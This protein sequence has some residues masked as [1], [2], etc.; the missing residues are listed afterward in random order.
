[1]LESKKVTVSIAG[2]GLALALALSGC[3]GKVVVN[4]KPADPATSEAALATSEAAPATSD[5][6]ESSSAPESSAAETSAA[7]GGDGDPSSLGTAPGTKLKLGQK[8]TTMTNSGK[9]GSDK[10]KEASYDMTVT[11]IVAGSNQDLSSFDNADKYKGLTPYY[12][13]TDLT[14]T[15]LSAP[16][17]G[18]SD[19]RVNGLLDNGKNANRLIVIGSFEK[20]KS[21]RFESEGSGDSFTYKVGSTKETCTVFL[22]P[23]GKQVTTIELTNSSY[24]FTKYSD[25]PYTQDPITWTK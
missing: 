12:V 16:S 11:K 19:P 17:A 8:A 21:G 14:L 6:P 25:N 18:I 5:A 3:A 20:C 13:F 23:E 24:S 4:E 15:K 1:M 2:L 22:A 10:Y 9:K 7:T